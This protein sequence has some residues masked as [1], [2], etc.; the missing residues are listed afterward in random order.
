MKALRRVWNRLL[1]SLAGSRR[2]ADM[3]DEFDTHLGLLT[4]DNLRRGLAPEEAR[5]Q[6]LLTF[7]GLDS[8]KEDYRDQRGLGWIAAIRQDLRY[9]IRGM[10]RSPGFTA[11]AAACLALGIGAN[12]AIFSILDAVMLRSLPVSQPGQLVMISYRSKMYPRAFRRTGSGYGSTSLPYTAYETIRQGTQTLSGVFAFVPLGFNNRSL[13]VN[14]GGTPSVAG[15]E[16][17]SGN[18][19][20]VLGVAPIAGRALTDDDLQPGAP[21]VTVVSHAYWMRE[22]GGERDAV[23]RTVDLNGAPFTIVG[24]APP[25]FFGVNPDLAPDVWVPLRDMPNIKPWGMQTKTS[26]FEERQ[27]WWCMMMGRLKA[28]ITLPQARSELDVLFQQDI[29][30]GMARLPGPDET[31]HISLAAAG[32][33]LELLQRRFSEPLRILEI[34]VGVVLL[35][36]CSNVAALLLARAKSRQREMGV[37]LA[38]GASRWR[39]VRQLLTESVVLAFCGGALGLVFARWGSQALLALM[40]GSGQSLGVDVR[41]DAAVLGFTAAVATLTG[42]LF[43]LAPAMRA[44]K[45]DVAAQLKENTGSLSPRAA[46]G[47]FLVGAQVALSVCLLFCAGLFVRTLMKLEN[48][49]FGFNRE[50]LLLFDL[51]PRGAGYQK[52]AIAGVYQSVLE[53]I[54]AL[55]GV[56]SASVSAF[57]LLSGWGNDSGIATDGEPLPQGKGNGVSWNPVGPNFIETMGIPVMLGRGLEWRDMSGQRVAVVN[58]AMARHFFPNANP[59]GHHFSFGDHFNPEHA[60]EIVGVVKTAKY[61]DVRGEPPRT[62]YVPYVTNAVGRMCFE[63]RTAGDPLAMTGALAGV[64]RSVDRNLPMIG[65]KT[66]VQQI[67]EALRLERMFARISSFFGGLALLL[68]GV[69]IYG[70][71]AYGVARR[72]GEIGIRIALGAGR[73][74]VLWMVLRE[75]LLVVGC[76]VAV[77]LPAAILLTRFVASMLFGVQQFDGPAIAGAVL[78]LV[79]AG[80][81]AG[82]LPA[83]RA[84]RIDPIK[85]LRYE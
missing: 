22:L 82:L 72:T 4:E 27:W 51:D 2:E 66:Q 41:P 1:G 44:T 32:R 31:P 73:F 12:T 74:E 47:K 24:V 59:V 65:V 42:I 45:V 18:F 29:T 58:D 15:G 50:K 9:A 33:G 79:A 21:N 80:V 19:F 78:I 8:A 3:A 70:T 30:K 39:L 56:R 61:Q 48:Q 76:G 71:M 7:G 14:L 16:M 84:S 13:T 68:V 34:A 83:R 40:S 64:V 28:G 75:S 38:V 37:R 35:I 17:V 53:K 36:A 25:Q 54:Q 57:A 11:V 49:D 55:P 20:Q 69:G 46:L 60:Y 62:A 10:R 63:V 5:R 52:E 43:G 67:D 81:A 6:A 85:A 26:L 23:G 77:G